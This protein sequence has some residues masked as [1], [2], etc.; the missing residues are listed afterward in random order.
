MTET[1]SLQAGYLN[2]EEDY[3]PHE[4][5]LIFEVGVTKIRQAIRD[6]RRLNREPSI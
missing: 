3:T 5:A 1:E 2:Q 4:L 6:Y